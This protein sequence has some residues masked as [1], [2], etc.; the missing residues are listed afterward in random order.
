M[1]KCQ[2]CCKGF[3]VEPQNFLNLFC[4]QTK[5]CF[6][7]MRVKHACTVRSKEVLWTK[8]ARNLT[9]FQLEKEK[10]NHKF[11]HILK[12]KR[13]CELPNV[14][15]PGNSDVNIF[16]K[17]ISIR[18]FWKFISIYRYSIDIFKM[19]LSAN[20][21]VVTYILTKNKQKNCLLCG[22]WMP[23]LCE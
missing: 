8:S 11:P 15:M 14:R 9:T 5:T 23:R 12:Y 1:W 21:W 22:R 20:L 18:Y 19:L 3:G 13:L 10:R 4:T 17:S 7:V 16:K 2:C 6:L